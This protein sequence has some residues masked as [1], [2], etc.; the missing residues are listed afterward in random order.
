MWS[1]LGEQPKCP[2]RRVQR[3]RLGVELSARG[4][5]LRCCWASLPVTT[6]SPIEAGLRCPQRTAKNLKWHVGTQ[7]KDRGLTTTHA[8]RSCGIVD[9]VAECFH[10]AT[11][12]QAR[13]WRVKWQQK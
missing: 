3:R 13:G 6:R 12:S 8:H 9:S 11:I 2:E 4:Y 7:E 1:G 5:E 10:G